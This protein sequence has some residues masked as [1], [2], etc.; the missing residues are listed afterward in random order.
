MWGVIYVAFDDLSSGVDQLGEAAQE[1]ADELEDRD[2]R[3]AAWH[4]TSRRHAGSSCSST[5]STTG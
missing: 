1:A 3:S 5:L 2:D 4:A